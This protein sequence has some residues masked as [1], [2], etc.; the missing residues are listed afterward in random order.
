[1]TTYTICK[2]LG[3][4]GEDMSTQGSTQVVRIHNRDGAAC[5]YVSYEQ[6][7]E[8]LRLVSL[9][10]P[11]NLSVTEARAALDWS[12]KNVKENSSLFPKPELKKIT[13][14]Q[15]FT[16]LEDG[17]TVV[18][19]TKNSTNE[20]YLKKGVLYKDGKKSGDKISSLLNSEW[21]ASAQV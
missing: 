3:I 10:A 11:L 8:D 7:D 18:R 20:Y 21:Y 4:I 12:E 17:A 6:N 15:A 5:G 14:T 1:M 13:F 16:K 9:D 19:K 2:K